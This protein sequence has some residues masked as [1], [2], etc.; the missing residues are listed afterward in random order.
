MKAGEWLFRI[1]TTAWLLLLGGA[2]IA[3][4]LVLLGIIDAASVPWRLATA[5]LGVGGL[6]AFLLAGLMA[7]WDRGR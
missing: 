7:V 3:G 4:L 1:G 6:V 2:L 5:V